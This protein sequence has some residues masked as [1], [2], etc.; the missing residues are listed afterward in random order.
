MR[1]KILLFSILTPF[2]LLLAACGGPTDENA[3]LAALKDEKTQIEAKIAA[4]EKE[5]GSPTPAAQRTKTVAIP[6]V[7]TTPFRHYID[8]QGKVD[9]KDN[10]P[11]TS[12]M[13]GVLTRILVK[14]G[15]NVRQGQL[16]AQLDNNVMEKSLAEL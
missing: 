4:L 5:V 15:D 16:L 6:E 13:P 11:V 8:L 12:K 3:E 7:T 1:H 2:V 14:N 9:A 10:V